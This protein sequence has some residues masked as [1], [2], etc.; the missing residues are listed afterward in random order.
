LAKVVEKQWAI[1]ATKPKTNPSHNTPFKEEKKPTKK[2]EY[3][4]FE[5]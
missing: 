1:S 5:E 2:L 4:D 3:V